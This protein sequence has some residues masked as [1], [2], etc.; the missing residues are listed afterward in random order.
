[1]EFLASYYTATPEALQELLDRED[2]CEICHSCTN[3]LCK[4][5]E[6]A[7]ILLLLRTG[8]RNEAREMVSQNLKI[9]PWNEFLLAVKHIEFHDVL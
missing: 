3:P 4:E 1:M 5:L 7:R 8:K 2:R 9:Q 6:G